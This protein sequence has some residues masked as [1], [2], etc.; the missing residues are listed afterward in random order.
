LIMAGNEGFLR[1]ENLFHWAD[2]TFEATTATA[3]YV[4]V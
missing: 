4:S 3:R 1:P 2:G